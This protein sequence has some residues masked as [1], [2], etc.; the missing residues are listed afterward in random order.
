MTNFGYY[1]LHAAGAND[2]LGL[3]AGLGTPRGIA[4]VFF[5]YLFTAKVGGGL[6]SEIGSMRISQELDAYDVEAVGAQS[7]VVG[8]RVIAALLYTPIAAAVTYVSCMGASL[9]AAVYVLHA[10]PL[11]TFSRYA[12]GS[13][14]I[15]DI[16]FAFT[17]IAV[18]GMV[19]VMVA[20]FYGFRVRG[21]P[22]E[23]GSAVARSMLIN[24]VLVHV[25]AGIAAFL[26]YGA[27][28][29]LPIGG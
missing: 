19:I 14:G 18:I 3:V 13:E 5:G 12:W 25:I 1:F 27:N 23:V 9:Y 22:A 11:A 26:V 4:E 21:G 16:V 7:Y 28:P 2:Y 17:T 8:T 20:C 29:H 10:V 15:G 6:V 24:L